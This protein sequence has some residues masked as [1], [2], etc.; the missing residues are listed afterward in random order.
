VSKSRLHDA[1]ELQNNSKFLHVIEELYTRVYPIF[2]CDSFYLH[3]QMRH[4]SCACCWPHPQSRDVPFIYVCISTLTL[5]WEM[6][7]CFH[8]HPQSR[9]VPCVCFHPQSQSRDGRLCASVSA[10]PPLKIEKIIWFSE[11][12]LISRSSFRFPEIYFDFWKLIWFPESHR[13][14]WKLIP[15]IAWSKYLIS[16]YLIG[17][18]NYTWN[19]YLTSDCF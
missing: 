15:G 18:L 4:V 5:N 16:A 3:P 17:I 19:K 14:S 8:F 12:D 13:V 11:T 1:N 6:H 2:V 7:L 9:D 10:L